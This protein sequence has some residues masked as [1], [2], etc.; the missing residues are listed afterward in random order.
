M[1]QAHDPWW[2]A[3]WTGS[4]YKAAALVCQSLLHIVQ[5]PCLTCNWIPESQALGETTGLAILKGNTPWDTNNYM[6][7]IPAS[8]D[9]ASKVCRRGQRLCFF[10]QTR[11]KKK[12]KIILSHLYE[13]VVSAYTIII[14]QILCQCSHLGQIFKLKLVVFSCIFIRLTLFPYWL[15]HCGDRLIDEQ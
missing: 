3:D 14:S 8:R 7:V 5:R 11:K 6:K 9:S 1:V 13:S 2:R 12:P 4:L 10:L 15:G